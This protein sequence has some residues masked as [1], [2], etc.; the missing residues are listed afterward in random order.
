MSGKDP[1]V[2]IALLKQA[3][4]NDE[5]QISTLWDHVNKLDDKINEQEKQLLLGKITFGVLVSLGV[6]VGWLLSTG[7]KIRQWFH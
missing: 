5:K 3:L 1:T 6:F 2:E 7:E 4:E